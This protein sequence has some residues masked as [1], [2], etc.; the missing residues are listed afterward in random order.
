V[1]AL[2]PEAVEELA[3][4]AVLEVDAAVGAGL[5][6]GVGHEGEPELQVQLEVLE[7]ALAQR[8]DVEEGA[9]GELDGLA[10][11]PLLRAGAVEQDDRALRRLLPQHRALALDFLQG[12][13][14]LAPFGFGGEG[15]AADLAGEGRTVLELAREGGLAVLEGPLGPDRVLAVPA[16]PGQ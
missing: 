4:V 1:L 14:D 13:L 3:L 8:A 11:H 6:A 5:P 16:G 2:E 12:G 9:V 10:A 15:F 7:G